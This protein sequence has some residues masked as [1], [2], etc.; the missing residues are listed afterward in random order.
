MPNM[1][2]EIQYRRALAKEVEERR[3]ELERER[4]ESERKERRDREERERE[5]EEAS[6]EEQEE[7][8]D[9]EEERHK[10]KK[11][12]KSGFLGFFGRMFGSSDDDKAK[13]KK[14]KPRPRPE[15]EPEP[16]PEAKPEPEPE[17]E[18]KPEK[19]EGIDERSGNE[20]LNNPLNGSVPRRYSTEWRSTDEALR[21]VLNRQQ[22]DN[23]ELIRTVIRRYYPNFKDD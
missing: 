18:A 22:G 5:R 23:R 16:E 12:E 7:D 6:D 8:E 20:N 10:N 14:P 11:E 17:P 21:A 13:K 4:A 3:K 1:E 9:K 15:P 19:S 2:R